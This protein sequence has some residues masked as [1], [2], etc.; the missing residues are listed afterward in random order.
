MIPKI[1]HQ[2]WVGDENKLPKNHITSWVNNHPEWQHILWDEKKIHD[3]NLIN[4]KKY[5]IYYK[6]KCY[7]GA[8]NVAR[9][10]IVNRYGGIYVD[11][12]SISTN[13]MDELVKLDFFAV[14]SPNI[15]GRVGNAFFG[16][17]PNNIILNEYIKEI[18]NLKKL[19]PSYQTSGGTTF[20]KV[21]QN[22]NKMDKVLPSYS[23]Y[24]KNGKGELVPEIGVNYA[25]HYWG[26]TFNKY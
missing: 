3:L 1:I 20:K 25:D 2:I 18:G 14:Y 22:L 15:I 13:P 16:S 21:L 9:V 8:A 6:E 26:T 5:E 10:E 23:F 4:K 11:A 7:N 12:D 19:H 17:E 24:I